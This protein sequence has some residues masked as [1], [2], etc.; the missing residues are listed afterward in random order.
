MDELPPSLPPLGK[1]SLLRKRKTF[2]IVVIFLF[3]VTYVGYVF[4]VTYSYPKDFPLGTEI[5]IRDGETLES[6]GDHLYGAHIIH[7]PVWFKLL[8]TLSSGERSI[9]AGEY[10]FDKR[11]NTV[12]TI[13]KLTRGDY[14]FAL[15]KVTIPEGFSIHQIA[16]ILSSKLDTFSAK[17]FIEQAKGKE[18]FLFPE[19][20]TFPTN[21]KPQA[22]IDK[23]GSIFNEKIEPLRA[24]I[25]AS[26]HSLVEIVTMG[27]LLEEEAKTSES[28]R[29]V[30]GILWNRIAIGMPLQV[31]A[32]F[33]Y[34]NGK[35]TYELTRQDLLIVSPYNTYKNKGLTPTPISNPGIDSINAAIHP[36]KTPYLYYLS[37]RDGTMH[38]A[39][40]YV[41]HLRNKALYI[42]R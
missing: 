5:T 23:M 6:I 41:E 42:P 9:R 40:T 16:E 39:K 17:E 32:A 2:L 12:E 21:A 31:D 19:T 34:I 3:L 26:K 25:T 24:D 33:L 27:S 10:R 30:S 36:T 38:Y 29:V 13:Q 22:V 15:V 35:N 1:P 8:V 20:Y 11:L 7:S 28:R 4:S 14:G 18:G 37:E